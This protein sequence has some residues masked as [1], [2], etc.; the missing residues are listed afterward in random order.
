MGRDKSSFWTNADQ[1]S[2]IVSQFVHDG[3]P[4]R[5][6]SFLVIVKSAKRPFMWLLTFE[7]LIRDE[8]MARPLKDAKRISILKFNPK[9]EQ[10]PIIP[11]VRKSHPSPLPKSVALTKKSSV[12]IPSGSA[13]ILMAS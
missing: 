2:L 9:D 3:D 5:P 7:D 8:V 10:R 4:D 6:Q 11:L 13:W 1:E 12:Q